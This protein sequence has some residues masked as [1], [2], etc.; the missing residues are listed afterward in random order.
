MSVCLSVCSSVSHA[1]SWILSKR[2]NISSK[3]FSPSG[4]HTILVYSTPNIMA[5]F[6]Q[7]GVEC[8]LGR[9]KSRFSTN[10]AVG[11]WL[12]Q[13]EQQVRPS[14]VQFAA[15][16][17]PVRHANQWIYVYHSQQHE[18]PRRRE[19]KRTEFIRRV[20]LKRNLRS[21]YWQTQ[22]NRAAFLR[23]QGFLSKH[24]ILITSDK[25]GGKCV[26]PRLSTLSVCLSVSKITQKSVHGFGWNVACRQMSGHGRTD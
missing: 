5:I 12:L 9:H 21:T 18:R 17:P 13:C 22:S 23:Q 11:R 26:C 1:R 2:I 25:G 4:S 8:R 14:T 3:F 6:P 16:T 7:R 24:R 20:N 10:L 19:K 15:H